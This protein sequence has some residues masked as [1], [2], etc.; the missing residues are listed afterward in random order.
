V[1]YWRQEIVH[2]AYWRQCVPMVLALMSVLLGILSAGPYEFL[3][4]GRSVT[5]EVGIE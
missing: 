3:Q 2:V 5:T 4:I 1:A